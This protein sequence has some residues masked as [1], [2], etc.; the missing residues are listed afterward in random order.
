MSDTGRPRRSVCELQHEVG[1]TYSPS[2][3]MRARRPELFSDSTPR[4]EN[5]LNKDVLDYRLSILTSRK[6]EIDFEHFC[7]RIAEQEICPNLVA[8]TGP[9]GGGDS[10]VDS[11]TYPVSE[12]I[13]TR[14]YQGFPGNSSE[15]RWAFAFSAK[16]E[17]RSKVRSDVESI[18]ST[19]RGYKHIYF[20]TNQ[21]VKDKSRSHVEDQ[22]TGKY[23]AR[24]H[25]LDRSWLLKCVFEH[26]RQDL[27]IETLHLDAPSSS[28]V[29][30]G[31]KDLARA[32]QLSAVEARIEDTSRYS[33]VEYQLVEDCLSAAVLS[34]NLEK[35][36]VET[37][38]RFSR[39][40]RIAD[41]V[42]IPKQRLRVAYHRDPKAPSKN[43]SSV[44]NRRA[45]SG[46][47]RHFSGRSFPKGFVMHRSC[48][49]LRE[50]SSGR[51]SFEHW[52]FESDGRPWPA[53]QPAHFSRGMAH[54]SPSNW[55]RVLF[56]TWADG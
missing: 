23:G 9:T 33:G 41:S 52:S 36:R 18:A 3:F 32:Q 4:T 1:G 55:R 22:L 56:A 25:I 10:K 50:R 14:W 51:G 39:A 20:I 35:P 40:E 16:S 31:P 6:Q 8:Q 28:T 49:C 21:Y 7:R 17:W 19:K 47:G 12:R 30:L 11:E 54:W 48:D 53:F 2:Q 44:A 26:G 5:Q 13:S 46:W 29:L 45:R 38:G 24:V 37:E 15:E 34:R 43:F 27:A 42:G